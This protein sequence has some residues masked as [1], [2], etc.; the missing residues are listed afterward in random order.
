LVRSFEALSSDT[1]IEV[2]PNPGME[3]PSMAGSSELEGKAVRFKWNDEEGDYDRSFVDG[4]GDEALLEKLEEDMDLRVFL[5]QEEVAEEGTWTVELVNLD[6]ILTPGGNL[7]LMPED[8]EVDQDAMDRLTEIFEGFAAK[9]ADQLEGEC[10]CTYKG[11]REEGGAN[12]AEIAIEL[13]VAA[14]LDLTE[15]FSEIIR[16]SIEESG[17][18]DQVQFSF[19]SADLSVDFEGSGTLLWNP[20]TG[21]PHSF[22]LSGDVTFGIDMALGIEAMGES[23]DVDASVELSGSVTHTVSSKQ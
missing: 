6:T 3:M 17:A 16:A 20:S 21:L 13:E 8:M 5:P 12:V 7:H 23:Q 11:L 14:T 15:V 2:S 22:Q 9:Y 19:D 18:G 10:K 4:E 1:N